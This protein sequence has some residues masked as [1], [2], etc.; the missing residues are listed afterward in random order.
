[1]GPLEAERRRRQRSRNLAI[2]AVLLG[3]VVLVYAVTIVRIKMG[4]R[5]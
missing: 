4:W 3:I 2:F 5:P 1:M